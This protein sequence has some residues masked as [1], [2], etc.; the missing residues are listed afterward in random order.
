MQNIKNIILGALLLVSSVLFSQQEGAITNYMYHMNAFNPAYVGVDGQTMITTTFRQQWSGVKDAPSS[1]VASF[2][3]SLGNNM[4]L[5]VSI[6]NSQTFVEK[7]TFT[8]IDF[9]YKVQLSEKANLYFGLKAGGN[10]YSVNTSG[11]ETYNQT[12]DPNITSISNFN[13]NIGVGALLKMEKW[14][15]SL[16]VPR[17][18]STDRAENED[19]LVTAAVAKPHVYMTTG[20]QF[21]LKEASNLQLKPSMMMR[22]VNGAPVSIDFNTMLNFDE[23][24]EIG[25]TYR[26]DAAFAALLN[27]SIKKS[28][29]IGY[30]YEVSTRKELASAT[31]EFFLRFLF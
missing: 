5:G 7:Q 18:L 14:H 30:A 26:T 22:Y 15:L 25:A 2:G 8:G 13:P 24:F 21:L 1:Q 31:N 23:N 16:A 10:F 27:F 9:S 28:L 29:L 20:Y 17:L 11:L 12:S 3:T 6:L 19:G 4:G